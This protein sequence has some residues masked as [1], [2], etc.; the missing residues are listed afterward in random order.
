[1]ELNVHLRVYFTYR[2]AFTV[3]PL[4]PWTQSSYKALFLSVPWFIIMDKNHHA[5]S[6]YGR[7]DGSK[8]G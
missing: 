8:K 5:W 4:G 2:E 1:M 3:G 7:I 6:S